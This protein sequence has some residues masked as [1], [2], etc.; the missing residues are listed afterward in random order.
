MF[1]R[2]HVAAGR[3]NSQYIHVDLVFTAVLRPPSY[4]TV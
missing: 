1:E 4:A 2:C 3:I